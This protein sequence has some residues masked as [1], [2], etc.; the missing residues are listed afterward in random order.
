MNLWI[1]LQVSV[2]RVSSGP[3]PLPPQREPLCVWGSVIVV[4][5]EAFPPCAVSCSD[6]YLEGTFLSAV[7]GKLS[8]TA[9]RGRAQNPNTPDQGSVLVLWLWIP[10]DLAQRQGQEETSSWSPASQRSISEA[11]FFPFYL[12]FCKLLPSPQI[13]SLLK[14]ANL[15]FCDPQPRNPLHHPG[16][17]QRNIVLTE[18]RDIVVACRAHTLSGVTSAPF[19]C[20]NCL[21]Q[22]HKL[23]LSLVIRVI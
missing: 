15:D 17:P 2:E 3:F 14:L 11:W 6:F 4:F 10:G 7:L 21:T 5:P 13:A 19:A 12:P 22:G 9:P 16:L 23:G 20:S 8:I 18:E 1:S